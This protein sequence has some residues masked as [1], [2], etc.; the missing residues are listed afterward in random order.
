MLGQ[1]HPLLFVIFKLWKMSQQLQS[2][3]TTISSVI[4]MCL[5]HLEPAT[6]GEFV[7]QVINSLQVFISFIS[8][9]SSPM[10]IVRLC[11]DK[12]RDNPR[13]ILLRYLCILS[14]PHKL[15]L[16]IQD[17][18]QKSVKL[19]FNVSQEASFGKSFLIIKL[20]DH[21]PRMEGKYFFY[22]FSVVRN[23]P[24]ALLHI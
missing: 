14:I 10:L 21:Y 16:I 17:D 13:G 5:I 3:S 20:K 2:P 9:Q 1:A 15:G 8:P 24:I 23:I 4:I 19:S 18:F 7:I 22:F 11:K 12:V 6:N